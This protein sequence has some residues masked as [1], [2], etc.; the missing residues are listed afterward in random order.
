MLNIRGQDVAHNPV[1]HGFAV[2]H[3]DARVDLFMHAQK[4]QDIRAHLGNE[5]TCEIQMTYPIIF[6]LFW[7]M[8]LDAGSVP[9]AISH[10]L[11]DNAILSTDPL[12][13]Q[14][15]AKTQQN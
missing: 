10:A 9:Y 4:A 11:S 15:R 14:R 7:A 3:D 13:F 6:H 8:R 2:L 5:V 12:A 1:V